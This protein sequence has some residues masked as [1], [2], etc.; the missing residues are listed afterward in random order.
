MR[1]SVWKQELLKILAW[2]LRVVTATQLG[3]S[4][5][6]GREL[7]VRR[8]NHLKKQGL[9]EVSSTSVHDWRLSGPLMVWP[10][11]SW[12]ENLQTVAWRLEKRWDS[13]DRRRDMVVWIAA[14]GIRVF[15]GFG[16]R[17]RQRLQLEHDLGVAA[18]FFLLSS[19][20]QTTWMGEDHF[21]TEPLSQKL[22]RVPDAVLRRSRRLTAIEFGG[23]YDQRKLMR[24]HREMK[25]KGVRY[26]IY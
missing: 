22:N 12:E 5:G 25:R 6:V 2:K 15:G 13:L 20:R 10:S 17:L 8:L 26:E 19:K 3:R 16:G 21:R 1:L 9:V 11:D 14:G 24:F 4:A 23:R 18:V 7:V